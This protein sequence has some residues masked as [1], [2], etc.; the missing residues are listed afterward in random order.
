MH[1]VVNLRGGEE[2]YVFS[3]TTPVLYWYKDRPLTFRVELY[4]TWSVINYIVSVNGKE[5]TPDA[6]GV[7]TIPAGS[8]RVVINCE[9]I[10]TP[11][12]NH[13]V[14]GYCGKVHPNNVFG[15]LISMMHSMFMFFRSFFGR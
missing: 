1:Y 2:Y 10:N 8:D 15:F 7:Y 12:E 11:A 6:N 5:L 14:C 3:D 13:D 9:P 4:S